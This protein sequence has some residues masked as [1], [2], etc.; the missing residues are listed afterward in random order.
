[1]GYGLERL[2]PLVALPTISSILR[3]GIGGFIV[4]T[5]VALF[6]VWPAVLFRRSGQDPKPWTATPELVLEGPY[7][8]TRNPMY[9]MMV[10]V[11]VGFA[12]ILVSAW[13]LLLTPLCGMILYLTAIRHEEVYLEK[14]FGD[15][16]RRYQ[17]RVR[18]W[19]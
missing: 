3:Y 16:Y 5:S 13:V 15:S 17:D 19:I 9:L 1:V 14:K 18:R 7:K 11:C 2:V 12:V 4:A 10:L 6:G 8:L